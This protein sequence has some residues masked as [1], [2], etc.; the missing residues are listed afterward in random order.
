MAA[1]MQESLFDDLDEAGLPSASLV[2]ASSQQPPGRCYIGHFEQ[3]TGPAMW[4]LGYT[5]AS[6]YVRARQIACV[7]VAWWPGSMA[8]ERR[9][10]KQWKHR[11]VSPTAEFFY[12]GPDI[13]RWVLGMTREMA[14]A[15]N[16]LAVL[17][18]ILLRYGHAA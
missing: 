7:L 10:H 17:A 1:H 18:E 13:D 2:M 9:M 16:Q 6:P 4:K 12:H 11:R 8:D 5:E 14:A 3:R 15:T